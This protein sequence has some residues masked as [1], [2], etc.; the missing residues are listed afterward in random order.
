MDGNAPEQETQEVESGAIIQWSKYLDGVG[1]GDGPIVNLFGSAVGVG[2]VA[3]IV[4]GYTFLSR[5]YDPGDNIYLVGFSRGAYTVR[6]LAGMIL[7]YG[8]LDKT[9]YNLNAIPYGSPGYP[10][11]PEAAYMLGAAV[12]YQ[13]AAAT[14]SVGNWIA[15]VAGL[16]NN[17]PAFFRAPAAIHYVQVPS[18]RAIGVW[19]TVGS[20]LFDA[21]ATND[22]SRAQIFPFAD[23]QLNPRVLNGYQALSLDELR[24]VFTPIFWDKAANVSQTVFAGGHANV[25]GGYSMATGEAQLSDIPLAWLTGKL[26]SEGLRVFPTQAFHTS[27]NP[28]GIGHQ[29]WRYSPWTNGFFTFGQRNYLGRADI[30][31]DPSISTRMAASSV[32]FDAGTGDRSTPLPPVTGPYRPRNMP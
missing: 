1:I 32:V 23:T 29:Q 18:I 7:K 20:Y 12:W 26:I 16:L 17:L 11:D 6:A 27:P 24:N 3:R 10:S 2:L 19:D 5:A 4:R 9:A 22:G 21:L 25:G 8:L 14:A 31:V 15:K 28:V 13:Y 30:L